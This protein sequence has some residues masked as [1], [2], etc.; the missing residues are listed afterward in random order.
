ML[1]GSQ[2]SNKIVKSSVERGGASVNMDCVCVCRSW[3]VFIVC[4]WPFLTS[5]ICYCKIL[6]SFSLI[7]LL[8]LFE[9]WL[10]KQTKTGGY[11][12]TGNTGQKQR[13]LRRCLFNIRQDELQSCPRSSYRPPAGQQSTEIFRRR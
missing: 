8:F 4:N 1:R 3:C 6:L 12:C 2:Q 9:P 13:R 10:L 5:H 7:L 11:E